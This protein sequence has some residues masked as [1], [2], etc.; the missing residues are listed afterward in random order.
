M[1]TKIIIL[2]GVSLVILGFLR[3]DAQFAV[4]PTQI[5]GAQPTPAPP[6]PQQLH[7]Q[8][9]LAFGAT[10]RELAGNYHRMIAL[11]YTT[12]TNG[13]LAPNLSAWA[14]LSPAEQLEVY[15]MLCNIGSNLNAVQPGAVQNPPSMAIPVTTGS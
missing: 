8:I 7:D 10:G 4:I 1:K 9:L 15:S 14:T 11:L 5:Q 2:I 6:S 3:A 12:D 13:A